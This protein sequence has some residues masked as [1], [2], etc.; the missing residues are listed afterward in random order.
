MD[1]KDIGNMR[2]Q[3]LVSNKDFSIELNLGFQSHYDLLK[4]MKAFNPE[5]RI[6]VIY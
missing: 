3:E 2:F 5:N 4:K 1:Y 6:E